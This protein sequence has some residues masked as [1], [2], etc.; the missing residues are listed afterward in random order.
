MCNNKSISLL[1]VEK[2]PLDASHSD[3]FV[4]ESKPS[5]LEAINAVVEAAVMSWDM[6]LRVKLLSLPICRYDIA[7]LDHTEILVAESLDRFH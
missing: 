5:E 4:R 1:G 7:D 3:L 6:P 2:T